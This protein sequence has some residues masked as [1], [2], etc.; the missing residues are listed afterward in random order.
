MQSYFRNPAVEEAP[1]NIILQNRCGNRL[2]MQ[3]YADRSE[4]EFVYKPNAYR[5]KDYRARNFSNRDNFTTLF[6]SFTLPD[7]REPD[8][9]HYD[10]DPFVTRF[11]T[12]TTSMAK[13]TVT[14]VNV[15]DEN[16]FAIAARS[17]LLLGIRPQGS[18]EVRD[19]LL[20][21][22]F[23]DRGEEIVAFVSFGGFE[24][25][26]YRVLDDGT[27]VLQM[28]ENEVILVGGEETRYHAQQAIRALGSLTLPELIA[29]NERLLAPALAKG[30]VRIADERF[31]QVLDLNR[32]VVYSGMDEGGAC[33]GALNRLYHLIWNR[34]GS[35]TTSL[36]ARSGNPDYLRAFAPFILRN[37][38]YVRRE[39]GTLVPEF[40][41]ILGTRWSKNEDDGIFYAF[42]ALFTHFATTGDDS[43]V[44]GPEFETALEAFERFLEKAWEP[45][46]NLIGSDTRGESPLKSNPYYGYDVVSGQIEGCDATE[47]GGRKHGQRILSRCYSLYY[48]VNTYNILLMAAVM[49]RQRPGI[50][51]GRTQRYLELAAKIQ[52][53]VQTAFVDPEG[54]LYAAFERYDDGNE[55]WMAYS[56]GVD[57]WEYAWANS[58]GPF[59]PAPELQLKSARQV[60]DRWASMTD[61]GFCPWNT[62][63]RYL[64]EYGM[65]SDRYRDM[66]QEEIDD[67]LVLGTK[68]PMYGALNEY[69]RAKKDRSRLAT[70]WRALPFTAGSLFYSVTSLLVQSLPL[71]V[72][73]RGSSLVDEVKSF[74]FRLA[75]IDARASGEGDMAAGVLLNGGTLEGSLQIPERMLRPGANTV[76]IVRGT[77]F[78]APRLYSS[79]VELL[80]C[81]VTQD[82]ITYHMSS[83]VPAQLV[84]ENYAKVKSLHVTD[85][86]GVK[87]ATEAAKIADTGMTLV[88]V[89]IDGDFEVVATV[90]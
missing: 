46:R 45:D 59:Y 56:T 48:N 20:L 10:Y 25:N 18:F 54:F 16:A 41:Q 84:F 49:L 86:T 89:D 22:S 85:A 5:R 32:R 28:F 72:A 61:Y 13:S 43:L 77:S 15:A 2:T 11:S 23:A 81:T 90:R 68:Y 52:S 27:H 30:R 47:G 24:Q 58:L 4:F 38:S 53:T 66:L 36:M 55:E 65:A 88:T 40:G 75:R 76:E 37:P 21:D 69:F 63:S 79:N 51:N 9:K 1:R 64:R 7:T 83:A 50:D 34:D 33:F 8:V 26:R 80:D 78:T 74:Q 60:R 82:A 39:D 14:V 73:I 67:A 12:E 17:P 71:G 87:R 62:V 42:L 31:Q 35:M 6:R 70:S 57:Y 29:R 19:G 44:Q 3:F